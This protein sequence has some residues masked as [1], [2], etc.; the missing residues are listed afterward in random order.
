MSPQPHWMELSQTPSGFTYYTC[1]VC[2]QAGNFRVRA[3]NGDPVRFRP[4]DLQDPA[5]AFR[6]IA[7]HITADR[8]PGDSADAVEQ[9]SMLVALANNIEPGV[10][11]LAEQL[12][13]V[14]VTIYDERIDE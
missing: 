13:G 11:Y 9:A 14:G 2:D 1:Y 7:D 12:P 4:T 5:T 6:L 10:A 3:T 8:A